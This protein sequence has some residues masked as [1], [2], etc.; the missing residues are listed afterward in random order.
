[1]LDRAEVE[2]G[3]RRLLAWVFL[4]LAAFAGGSVV[5]TIL[6]PDFVAPLQ[7]TPRAARLGVLALTIGFIA[8]VWD[9][10]REFQRM[11]SRI[12]VQQMLAASFQNRLRVIETLLD[13][14]DKVNAPLLLTDVLRV[15]LDSALEIVPAIGGSVESL[16]DGEDGVTVDEVYSRAVATPPE[17]CRRLRVALCN[18]GRLVG[19]L[20]LTLDP[21]HPAIEGDRLEV[22]ERFTYQAARAMEKARLF[23]NE[24][25][26]VTYLQAANAVRAN[27]L[28]TVSHE[29]R[30]PLTSIIG[31]AATLDNHWRR[32]D[33][34]KRQEFVSVVLDQGRN[35]ARI[36]ERMLEAARLEMEGTIVEPI[37]H[38]LRS[39]LQS[40]VGR[41]G[42][43]SRIQLRVPDVPLMA[44]VDPVVVDQVVSNLVDNALR[45]TEGPVGVALRTRRGDAVITIADRGQGFPLE[46]LTGDME[47]ATGART[48]SRSGAG[49]GLKIV[50]ILVEAH[51]GR[52][53]VDR[54]GS[55]HSVRVVLPRR[56]QGKPGA[57]GPSF[58]RD[59]TISK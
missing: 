38:D 49:L 54:K 4:I 18:E 57:L 43:G 6:G 1:M 15:V 12:E 42:E 20:S 13:T 39:S 11:S 50:K 10:E 7:L 41:F 32:L 19:F 23:A 27:F 58:G 17:G 2:K 33:D 22:L 5:L 14:S 40:A 36:V 56:F 25:A 28:S 53:E 51:R 31:Y 44:E 55:G 45:Y 59:L 9:K 16:S 3:R 34:D 24:R 48:F 47:S 21:G 29:L 8:L 52:V 46:A 35:L 30:T 26:S 37:R